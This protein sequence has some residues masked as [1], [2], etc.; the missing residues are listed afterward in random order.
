MTDLIA[1][2]RQAARRIGE[3]YAIIKE[4]AHYARI[5]RQ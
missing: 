1:L 4:Q 5:E 3:R 2:A